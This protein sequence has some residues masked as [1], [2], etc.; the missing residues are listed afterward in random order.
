MPEAKSAKIGLGG[1]LVIQTGALGLLF[2]PFAPSL[3]V[4]GLALFCNIGGW[5]ALWTM[6]YVMARQR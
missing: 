6:L 1:T 5:I 3:T 2:A 4:W